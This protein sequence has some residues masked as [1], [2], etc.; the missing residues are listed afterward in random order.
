M[1]PR[2][3]VES[4]MR[5]PTIADVAEL[6]QTS[7]GTVSFVI[8]N[9]PGVA[10]ATRERVLRAMRELNWTPNRT[11]RALSTSRAYAIGFILARDAMA[12]SSDPFFAPFIAG[13]ETRLDESGHFLML[14]FANSHE[15]ERAAYL[16]LMEQ[17]RVDGFVLSDLTQDDYRFDLLAE[18]SFPAVTLNVADRSTRL[19]SVSR[20]DEPGVAATVQHLIELGHR[21]IAYV[22]GPFHYLHV[23]RRRATWEATLRDSGI[24]PGPAIASDF[25]ASGGSAATAQLLDLPKNERPTAIVFANDLMAASGMSYALNR[26]LRVPEDLS[27]TG[28]DDFELAAFLSPS[29]TTV[30]T[31][32]TAW[33]AAAVDHLLALINGDDP[34]DLAL[35]PPTLITRDSTGPAP[36]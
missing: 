10:T 23:A 36:Q 4:P 11:A 15:S 3:T 34:S 2:D 22:G 21:R 33:G 27:I 18:H 7:R 14:R 17:R 16:R 28:Y 5:R 35:P 9:R 26:G 1:A 8:N 12:L 19:P 31:D 13:M 6:A 32:P 24:E 20:S 29:L 30:R 25:T